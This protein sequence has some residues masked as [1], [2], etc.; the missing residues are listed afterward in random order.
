VIRQERCVR[1]TRRM[2][3]K[4]MRVVGKRL[5]WAPL[6]HGRGSDKFRDSLKCPAS[7]EFTFS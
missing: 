6:L 2:P 3:M 1:F 7:N 5:F 4:E